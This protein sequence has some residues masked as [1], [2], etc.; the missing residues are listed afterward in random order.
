MYIALNCLLNDLL[1]I[2]A[3]TSLQKPLLHLILTITVA[4]KPVFSTP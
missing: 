4:L 2:L 3:I 1:A